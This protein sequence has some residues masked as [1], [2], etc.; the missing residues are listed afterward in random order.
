M[1][2][3]KLGH[4]G[5]LG[6]IGSTSTGVKPASSCKGHGGSR[7][8]Y[9]WHILNWV[10]GLITLLI[11]RQWSKALPPCHVD[12]GKNMRSPWSRCHGV[13]GEAGG[14]LRLEK[15]SWMP[16]LFWISGP[17]SRRSSFQYC[18]QV[19]CL[20]THVGEFQVPE[21]SS[22]LVLFQ[23]RLCWENV[24]AELLH[25]RRSW[26]YSP[27]PEI[28]NGQPLNFFEL[29][30]IFSRKNKVQIFISWFFWLSRRKW[31]QNI[32][33]F[34]TWYWPEKGFSRAPKNFLMK[35][36]VTL[37]KG[38]HGRKTGKPW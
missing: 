31:R 27:E 29:H 37:G 28:A 15:G 38:Q 30:D 17:V 3:R 32:K 35:C 12:C 33:C 23:W 26:C 13:H 2:L 9:K 24:F 4:I 25:I 22:T 21:P 8:P 19:S 11:G 6:H 20:P 34:Y 14:A 5:F 1:G 10:T 18:L 36:R 7:G 16:T